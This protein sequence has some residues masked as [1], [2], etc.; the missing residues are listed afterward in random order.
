[1]AIRTAT[2]E[3]LGDFE[4]GAGSF[5]GA[6]GAFA[7]EYSTAS[8]F[9]ETGGTNPEEL[10]AAAHASCFSMALSLALSQAG[11]PPESIRTDAK[12]QILKEGEGFAI[13][14]IELVTVGRVPGAD[15]AAFER[16]A[17]AAKDGCPISQALAAVPEITLDA[18]LEG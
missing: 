2:A 12:V 15:A 17:R 7:G 8:R 14:R 16:A 3:W 11:T 13:K 9:G 1:M 18:T 10:V 6:S 4:S 5:K